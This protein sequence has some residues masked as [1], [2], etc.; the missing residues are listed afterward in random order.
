MPGLSRKHPVGRLESIDLDKYTSRRTGE[1]A[2]KD[3][4]VFFIDGVCIW[5]VYSCSL[6]QAIGLIETAVA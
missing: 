3:R 4:V 2:G 1:E 6:L 5:I